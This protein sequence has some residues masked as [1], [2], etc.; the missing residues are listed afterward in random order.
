MPDSI[1][2]GMSQESTQ[3]A[4]QQLLANQKELQTVLND[5]SQTLVMLVNSMLAQQ[6]RLDTSN[7]ITANIEAGTLPVVTTVGT[8]NT[9]AGGNTA[10]MPFNFSDAGLTTIY[11][12]L[13]VS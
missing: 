8:L 11:D 13:K 3:L 4:I 7:R 12:N 1:L 10:L 5:L 2:A 6:P 9:L